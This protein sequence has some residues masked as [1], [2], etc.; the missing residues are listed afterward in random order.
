VRQAGGVGPRLTGRAAPHAP[1]GF[2]GGGVSS[3]TRFAIELP[4][5]DQGAASTA[6]VAGGVVKQ[7]ERAAGKMAVV[8]ADAAAAEAAR[9]SPGQHQ[10]LSLQQACQQ[11]S[12]SLPLLLVAPG[13]EDVRSGGAAAACL[14]G[15][16]LRPLAPWR[17]W[18][19]LLAWPRGWRR[20][21]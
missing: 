11:D 13:V 21:C 16:R 17:P 19:G 8:Y 5:A 7:L 9:R 18:H 15:W 20:T 12:L 14:V 6:Q 3:S 10:V 2:S 1:Q 4:V